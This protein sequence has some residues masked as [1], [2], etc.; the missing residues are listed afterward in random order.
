MTGLK[1]CAYGM[2][3]VALTTGWLTFRTLRLVN[4]CRELNY[5]S[6]LPMPMRRHII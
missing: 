4:E 5:R 3:L 2:A 1:L 6:G